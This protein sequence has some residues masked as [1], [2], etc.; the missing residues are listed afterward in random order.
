MP[1]GIKRNMSIMRKEGAKN[2]M[3]WIAIPDVLAAVTAGQQR[4][5]QTDGSGGTV[6][7]RLIKMINCIKAN[8][9]MK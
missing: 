6:R 1:R 4:H 5:L 2:A 9:N 7:S 8:P 3:S